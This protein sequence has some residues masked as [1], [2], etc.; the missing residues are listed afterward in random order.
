MTHVS[1]RQTATTDNFETGFLSSPS[2]ALRQ[3]ICFKLELL[4]FYLAKGFDFNKSQLV[5][6]TTY[7]NYSIY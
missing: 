7:F 4:K 1:P 3:K 6:R 2:H 5:A